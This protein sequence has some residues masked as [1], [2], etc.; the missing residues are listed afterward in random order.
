MT[1]YCHID[2]AYK[3]DNNYNELD[4]MAREVNNKKKIKDIYK[5]YR[6]TQNNL[7]KGLKA[8]EKTQISDHVKSNLMGGTLGKYDENIDNNFADYF[9][10]QGNAS[11]YK[12]SKYD[13]TIIKDIYD[14]NDSDQITLDSPSEDDSIDDSSMESSESS[15]EDYYI[16]NI[17]NKN[18]NKNKNKSKR[19]KSCGDF[20]LNS[21]D[22]LES[23]DSG[24]SLLSHA[25]KCQNCKNKLMKLIRKSYQKKKIGCLN[26]EMSDSSDS[27]DE[28]PIIRRS[29]EK[30]KSS[31]PEMKELIMVCLLGLLIIVVLDLMMKGFR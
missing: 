4:R 6:T 2:N 5:Q 27:D 14:Q 17:A 12:P 13:D 11:R 10:A 3:S 30:A 28:R 22:S 24:E 1:S 21:V 23:L 29:D 31:S 9:S 25:R 8:Y 20:D 18:K 19:N 7:E 16:K 15:L 26:S